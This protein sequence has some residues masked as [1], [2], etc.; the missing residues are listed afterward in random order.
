MEFTE[1]QKQ[2]IKVALMA[3]RNFMA[4]LLND[5]DEILKH[6]NAKTVYIKQIDEIL[7]IIE[8]S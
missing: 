1:K 5:I 2:I 6:S 3:H 4:G 7:D 8:K